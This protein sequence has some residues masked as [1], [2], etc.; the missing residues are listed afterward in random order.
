V[1]QKK[2]EKGGDHGGGLTGNLG[3]AIGGGKGCGK[4]AMSEERITSLRLKWGGRR[5]MESER[6]SGPE[7]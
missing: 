2:N 4:G 5:S 7:G 3:E 6:G 1:N